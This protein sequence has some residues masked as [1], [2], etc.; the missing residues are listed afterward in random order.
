MVPLAPAT[1]DS[2]VVVHG[3]AF[4]SGRAA[5]LSFV[6]CENPY[7]RAPEQPQPY[8]GIGPEQAPAGTRSL[9]YDAAGGNAVGSVHYV[10]SMLKTTVAGMSVY[11]PDGASG[12]TYAGYQEPADWGTGKVWFGRAALTAP[13]GSWTRVDAAGLAFTWAKYD[14]LSQRR[15][16]QTAPATKIAAFVKAH[17]GDGPGFFTIGFGCD[18]R[19]FN[20]DAW[21]IGGPAGVTTY[22]LEGLT[23]STSISGPD[24]AIDA[25]Q[26]V[27][28]RGAVVDNTGAAIPGARL[29]LESQG[30][31]GGWSLV[32]GAGGAD[33]ALTVAPE[34]TTTYRWRFVDRPLAEGSASAPFTVEVRKAEEQPP[35]K[36]APEKAQKKPEQKAE[37]K[38]E[39][40]PEQKAEPKAEQDADQEPEQEQVQEQ[41]LE[42]DQQ[43]RR[44]R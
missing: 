12:V 11:A 23:T 18:G 39:K 21:R 20:M 9:G 1:A 33:P 37:P 10:D 15:L 28:L 36:K 2:T 26:E 42:K 19:A 16:D 44:H 25:G 30:P 3:T 31:N 27:T 4:P 43:A 22:D 29:V 38:A 41:D 6:G 14:M 5:Q 24:G 8:V 17:G 34:V 35:Q 40:K 7:L 32:E 13:A